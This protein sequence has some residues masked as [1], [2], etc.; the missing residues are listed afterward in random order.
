MTG[1]FGAWTVA[2]LVVAAIESVLSREEM[3]SWGWRLPYVTSLIPGLLLVLCRRFLEETADFEQL[4]RQEV[5]SKVAEQLE[6]GSNEQGTSHRKSSPLGRLL[7]NH[8]LAVLVGA[9]GTCG[10][11]AIWFVPPIYGV[12]FIQQFSGLPAAAATWSQMVCF[13]VPTLLAPAVGMLIDYVGVGKVYV[14]MILVGAV[15]SPAPLFYWWAHVPP[16]GAVAAVFQGQ[17]LLGLIQALTTATYL[18]VVELFPVNVR[19]TGVA[20]SY[21]IGVGICGGL[22]PLISDAG[23]LV[24]APRGPV[25]APAAFTMAMGCV[26][27]AAVAA[28]HVLQRKGYMRLTH[29]RDV[30]Y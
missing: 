1:A 11:G 28:S 5:Q 19:G 26:S 14:F 13:L 10:V 6:E 29:L 12:S 7:R 21:N 17:V 15:L 16:N 8:K 23:N 18:W 27:L 2:A 3:I 30:P 24:L 4:L 22:G 25:S 9:F 20:I